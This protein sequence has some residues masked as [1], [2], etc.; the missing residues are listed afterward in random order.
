MVGVT[1]SKQARG[2]TLNNGYQVVYS[3]LN[4]KKV[5]KKGPYYYLYK[6]YK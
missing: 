1:G 5:G 3:Q 2:L 4:Y 6:G